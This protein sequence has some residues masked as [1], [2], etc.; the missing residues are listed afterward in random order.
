M[1]PLWIRRRRYGEIDRGSNYFLVRPSCFLLAAIALTAPGHSKVDVACFPDLVSASGEADDTTRNNILV[2]LVM[3]PVDLQWPHAGYL[4]R[5]WTHPMIEL[6]NL[7]RL[8]SS[9]QEGSDSR[10]TK[11]LVKARLD[12]A[13]DA[14]QRL[15]MPYA[16]GGSGVQSEAGFCRQTRNPC[17]APLRPTPA[18]SHGKLAV[19]VTKKKAESLWTKTKSHTTLESDSSR[20]RRMM[21]LPRAA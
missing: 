14:G 4:C 16:I 6:R 2:V 13:P 18:R 12:N 3:T 8:D 17:E 1:L 10:T 15:N 20:R 19:T 5:I 11:I 21:A 9:K 7:L